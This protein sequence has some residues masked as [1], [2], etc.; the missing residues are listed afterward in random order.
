MGAPNQDR[1]GAYSPRIFANLSLDFSCDDRCGLVQY[2]LLF[3]TGRLHLL[4]HHNRP[5]HS[6]LT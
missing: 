4:P 1:F 2:P 6:H 3:A 5:A